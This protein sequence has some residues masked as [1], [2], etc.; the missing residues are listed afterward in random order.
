MSRF[1]Y[2]GRKTAQ[3]SF[4]LGGIGTGCIGLGG[5]GRL[6]D[7]EI[8][9]RPNKGS[10]NGFSHFAIK[11][12]A[13]GRVLDARVLNGDLPP[14]YSGQFG[15]GDFGSFGFGEPR[16]TTAGM[17]HFRSTEFDGRFPIA[18]VRFVDPSF[19]GRVRMTALNPFIPGNEQDSGIPAALFEFEVRNTGAGP[20]TYTLAGTLANPLPAP[21]VHTVAAQGRAVTLGTTGLAADDP[22]YGDLTL[23]TDASDWAV[24]S[25][26][27][28]GGWNDNLEVYWRDFTEPGLPKD[29]TYAADE[30]G[31][32]NHAT[33]AAR[34]TVPPGKA[35]KVRFVISWSFP[36]CTN[37]WNAACGDACATAGLPRTWRNWYATVW[38]TSRE[39]ARYALADWKRL[40]AE[41]RKFRDALFGSTL[42]DAALDAVSANLSILKS[43]TVMRLEDGTFYGFE[44][45]HPGS[46]CCEGSC[47]HVW[48]YAQALPFLFPGLERSMREADYRHN[49]KPSGA[50]PFR[51]QLPLGVEPSGFRPCA[52]GQFGGVMK[53]YRDWRI[54]GDTEWL[55]RLWPAVKASIEFAWSPENPD[56]WDPDKTGVLWGRQHHTLDM[57][58]FGPN[59]WLTGFYLGALRAGAEMADALG[60]PATAADYR[61]LANRG[62]AWIDA[63]VFNGSYYGQRVDLADRATLEAFGAL[64]YWSEEHGEIKYQVGDGCGID[65]V[66]A[67]WHADLYGLDD[68]LDPNH[69]RSALASLYAHNFKDPIR[70]HYNPWRLFCLNDEAGLVMCDW[71]EGARKPRIPLTYAQETMHGFEYAAAGLMISRG[72]VAEGERVVEAVRARYDGEARNPWNE[73]ECG[74]N[75]ARSMASYGLLLTYSGFTFDARRRALGFAPKRWVNGRFRCFWSVDG[76][77]G[78]IEATP[79]SCL[80]RVLSGALKLKSLG[81]WFDATTARVDEAAHRAVTEEDGMTLVAGSEYSCWA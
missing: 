38:P 64:E 65:Q 39:S 63:N 47:T 58:L 67:Q 80:L 50:M 45:C 73:I 28:R 55:R 56:R 16:Q 19:P 15:L 59:A 81:I 12:E 22:G 6:L 41:T 40:V 54:C 74:S 70:N 17:P 11:A 34:I 66:L 9:N 44:G 61:A 13:G 75:Y 60:D 68:L 21:N 79:T 43:P 18:C 42:P 25:Y 1:T 14:P 36:N 5:N 10:F 32:D 71:P 2:K 52:D 27:Y 46:G 24:Q 76:A 30:V 3:I 7:W 53:T 31:R 35:G 72:L 37:Y 48:N 29:R 49:L 26:W 78:E 57:E 51:I 23:A 69:V 4:P 77:W 20:I 33:L 62:R 8:Y